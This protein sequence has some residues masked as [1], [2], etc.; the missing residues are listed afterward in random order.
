MTRFYRLTILFSCMTLAACSQPARE[1]MAKDI[2]EGARNCTYRCP[3]GT[4]TN[5]RNPKC[6]LND[7]DLLPPQNDNVGLTGLQKPY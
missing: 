5:P 3:D 1:E 4:I 2:C 6:P 7:R